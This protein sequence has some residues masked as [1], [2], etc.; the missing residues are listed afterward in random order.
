MG[1]KKQRRTLASTFVAYGQRPLGFV[2][3]SYHD[4]RRRVGRCVRGRRHDR[5]RLSKPSQRSYL[6][7]YRRTSTIVFD[8]IFSDGYE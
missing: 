5:H 4:V 1:E 2:S 3:T 6:I 8:R 7:K